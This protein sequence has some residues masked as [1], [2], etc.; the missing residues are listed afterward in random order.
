MSKQAWKVFRRM[1][2]TRAGWR[3]HDFHTLYL[4]FGFRIIP[5]K[6]HDVF[7]H[8]DYPDLDDVIPRHPEELP[9][10]YANN[11]V[12]NTELLLRRTGRLDE[13]D[14]Q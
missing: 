1:K 11:A 8:P 2:Q 12:K 14:D 4:G 7:R 3:A 9:K 13:E 6:K 10:A 5:G